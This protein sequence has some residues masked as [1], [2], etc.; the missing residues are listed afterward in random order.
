QSTFKERD[1]KRQVR[2]SGFILFAFLRLADLLFC[3]LPE[4]LPRK[5]RSA[6]T[7]TRAQRAS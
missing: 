1:Q 6:E 5:A 2:K 7:C 4:K 3:R